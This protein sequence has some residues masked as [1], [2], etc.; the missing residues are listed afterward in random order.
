MIEVTGLG[1]RFGDTVALADVSF[2]VAPGEIVGFL[3]P[4][5]AGK[6]T[7]MKILTCSLAPSSG[8]A[9]VAGHDVGAEPL[10]VRRKVGFMPEHVP[11]YPDNA[12]HEY[13][14]FV[15]DLKGVPRGEVEP[16]LE[17]IEV[18]TGLADV[19]RRLIGHLS[20]GYRQR[21]G[22]AQALVGDPDI[23]ILDEPTA[24]LDPHQIVEIR[25]LVRGFRGR[26]TVLLSSHILGEVSLL[27]ERVLILDRG[28]LVAEA[29]PR[30]LARRL[31]GHSRVRL[32]WTGAP[33]EVRA[34][35]AAVDGVVE[36]DPRDDGAEVVLAGDPAEL[37]PRLV[38]TVIAAGGRLQQLED[39]TPTL[40]DLFLRLTRHGADEGAD[41]ADGRD[42]G[43]G[44]GA[45]GAD[46]EG[47]R[48]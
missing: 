4:N 23:L 5:G 21:V 17:E 20:K 47:G 31:D 43:S 33:D 11:L 27:C 12:V 34:A 9:V 14:C 19:R 40:E 8:R 39:R 45:A 24:G 41:P 38:E 36:V 16:H 48:P 30:E 10:A 18:R 32:V 6:T 2:R 35:L 42:A 15:A 3:G 13:L 46:G 1:R 7:T 22:L 28:R 26:R 37:R 44:N 25:E 29:D